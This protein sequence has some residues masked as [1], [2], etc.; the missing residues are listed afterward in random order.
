MYLVSPLI[1]DGHVHIINKHSH[2]LSCRRAVGCAHA[3]IHITLYCPL[4]NE[5]ADR[6]VC[7]NIP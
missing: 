4:L 1:D 5:R 6:H 7:E 2:L 3:F